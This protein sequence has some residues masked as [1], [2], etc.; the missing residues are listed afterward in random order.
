[1]DM[2]PF[3]HDVVFSDFMSALSE[4]LQSSC[5]NGLRLLFVLLYQRLHIC[6]YLLM[7]KRRALAF[8][9]TTGEN[10]KVFTASHK[11]IANFRGRLQSLPF[12]P[13]NAIAI[14]VART[15]QTS[16][17]PLDSLD[18]R[19][20]WGESSAFPALPSERTS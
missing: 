16:A 20:P 4:Y 11:I 9:A 13:S 14:L 18:V 3:K 10:E 2:F 5:P 19:R 15:L 7:H 12:A 17:M 6:L 1:M 8:D